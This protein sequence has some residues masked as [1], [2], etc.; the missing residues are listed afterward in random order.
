MPSPPALYQN[1]SATVTMHLTSPKPSKHPST[2]PHSSECGPVPNV[3]KLQQH[4]QHY[5]LSIAILFLYLCHFLTLRCAIAVGYFVLV[6]PLV[7]CSS[8]YAF[9]KI[10]ISIFTNQVLSLIHSTVANTPLF[11]YFEHS[12]P[13]LLGSV[14]SYHI[15]NIYLTSPVKAYDHLLLGNN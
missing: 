15:P 8:L 7:F 5:K 1:E 4:R 11:E 2:C 10:I 13:N 12:I 9:L 14:P 6:T 3:S